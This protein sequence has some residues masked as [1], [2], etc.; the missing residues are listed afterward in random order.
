MF[1][2]VQDFLEDAARASEGCLTR[3]SVCCCTSYRSR[4]HSTMHPGNIS[5]TARG[6]TNALQ[7]RAGTHGTQSYSDSASLVLGDR[8]HTARALVTRAAT[9]L[10]DEHIDLLTLCY[11][12]TVTARCSRTH[13]GVSGFAAAT[14]GETRVQPRCITILASKFEI[15]RRC[16]LCFEPWCVRT[17]IYCVQQVTLIKPA[18]PCHAGRLTIPRGYDRCPVII[19]I[20]G[21]RV[22]S[23]FTP[24][25]IVSSAAVQQRQANIRC[26]G[27]GENPSNQST[28][29]R[30]LPAT[31]STDRRQ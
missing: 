27:I 7:R 22:H 2:C 15:R 30:K 24:Y 17:S 20:V 21:S 16:D 25:A 4:W 6:Q 11:R 9:L 13:Q 28:A 10:S 5:L 29:M 23:V 12:A 1:R 3:V 8:A 26:Q 19:G 31:L 14:C 18:R